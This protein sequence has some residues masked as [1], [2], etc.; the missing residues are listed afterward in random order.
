MNRKGLALKWA[1]Q[2]KAKGYEIVW[3]TKSQE[4][5]E[6]VSLTKTS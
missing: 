5:D 3:N 2:S 6:F 1:N 4:C